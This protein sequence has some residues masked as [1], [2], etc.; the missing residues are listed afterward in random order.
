[1]LV[2]ATYDADG[3]IATLMFD[4]A[5]DISSISGEAFV[6]DDGINGNHMVGSGV[7][8]IAGAEGVQVYFVF[9]AP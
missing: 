1:M 7:A 6:V 9:N 8:V 4:R 3:P 5:I 2:L